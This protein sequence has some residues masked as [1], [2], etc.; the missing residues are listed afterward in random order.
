MAQIA[1]TLRRMDRATVTLHLHCQTCGEPVTV[2]YA[3]DTQP[4]SG[5]KQPWYCPRTRCSAMQT[6]RLHGF[7]TKVWLGHGPDPS[8]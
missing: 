8:L 3:Q 5:V 7:V 4:D 1:L 2:Q 6:A